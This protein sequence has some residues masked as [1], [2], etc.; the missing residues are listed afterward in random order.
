MWQG[1]PQYFDFCFFGTPYPNIL[2]RSGGTMWLGTTRLSSVV[3]AAAT[4]KLPGQ[5]QPGNQLHVTL[6]K[7]FC[8]SQR[9]AY[10]P[11]DLRQSDV[12]ILST[13][14]IF[15]E[16]WWFVAMSNCQ[17]TR[18]LKFRLDKIRQDMFGCINGPRQLSFMCKQIGS[19]TFLLNI[20]LFIPPFRY[21]I[22]IIS[23]S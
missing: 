22:L 15:R 12:N 19:L 18:G 4:S 23:Q 7:I 17:S 5:H 2:T 8:N 6:I 11:V 3:E 13:F 9:L 1:T 14:L 16:R 21:L 10:I 20:E